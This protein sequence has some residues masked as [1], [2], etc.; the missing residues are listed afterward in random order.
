MLNRSDI[1][2]DPSD[3]SVK[4]GIPLRLV[5]NVSQIDGSSCTSLA[6]AFVD[7]WQCDALGV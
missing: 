4:E 7:V 5:F 1:R 3:G 6:G 2:S